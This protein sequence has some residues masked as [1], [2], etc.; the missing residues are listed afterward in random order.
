MGATAYNCPHKGKGCNAKQRR[1]PPAVVELSGKK[2]ARAADP[3]LL[4][5]E[6]VFSFLFFPPT[7]TLAIHVVR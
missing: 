6:V 7:P 3:A 1:G 4:L 5:F 2:W